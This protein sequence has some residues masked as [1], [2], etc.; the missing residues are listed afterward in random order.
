[1]SDEPKLRNEPTEIEAAVPE[2][3]PKLRNEPIAADSS[4]ES[5]GTDATDGD[6]TMVIR[7]DG[8]LASRPPAQIQ[9]RQRTDAGLATALTGSRRGR[10]RRERKRRN[11]ERAAARA[12]GTS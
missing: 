2:E 11:A 10:K 4:L 12:S 5:A 7:V 3:R 9:L 8:I 6:Q 1:M